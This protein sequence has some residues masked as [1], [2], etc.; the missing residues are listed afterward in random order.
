LRQAKVFCESKVNS[1]IE[2]SIMRR[3]S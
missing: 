3:W 1:L 2:E